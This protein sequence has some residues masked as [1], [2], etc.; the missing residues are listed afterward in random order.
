MGGIAGAADTTDSDE[1]NDLVTE[2]AVRAEIEIL[3]DVGKG[4]KKGFLFEDATERGL[5]ISY[6][7]PVTFSSKKLTGSGWV[8]TD[9]E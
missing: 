1:L 6:P 9:C 2:G 8:C 7:H 3:E 4:S 5:S